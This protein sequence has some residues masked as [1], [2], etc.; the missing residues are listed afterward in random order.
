MSGGKYSSG[1]EC[2]F[3]WFLSS[4][5]PG[6]KPSPPRAFKLVLGVRPSSEKSDAKRQ[7]FGTIPLLAFTG[8]AKNERG[9][10]EMFERT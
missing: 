3:W 9:S 10:A 7:V 1:V 5:L 6:G 8:C 2:P 4:S